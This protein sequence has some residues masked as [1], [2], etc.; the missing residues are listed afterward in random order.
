MESWIHNDSDSDCTLFLRLLLSLTER[1]LL[2]CIYPYS[3]FRQGLRTGP[4]KNI[5]A[6]PDEK[7]G[8]PE[9][10]FRERANP[11]PVLRRC[12]IFPVSLLFSF[13]VVVSAYF[14]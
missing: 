7:M 4:A 11:G 13:H 12:P 10:K 8:K 1:E 2:L 9:G 14:L 5:W 6:Y 3:H